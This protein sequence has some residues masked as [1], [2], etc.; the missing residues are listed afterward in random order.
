MPTRPYWRNLDQSPRVNP[1]VT[2]VSFHPCRCCKRLLLHSSR[3]EDVHTMILP[4]P[5]SRVDRTS[6]GVN[7]RS[8]FKTPLWHFGAQISQ[9]N[10]V[11]TLETGLWTACLVSRAKIDRLTWIV[12]RMVFCPQNRHRCGIIS[13]MPFFHPQGNAA[14][15]AAALLDPLSSLHS[16]T[17]PRFWELSSLLTPHDHRKALSDARPLK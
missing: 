16:D 2:A 10:P 13:Q 5:A 1:K 12:R 7:I 4:C 15:P 3:R 11:Y 6:Q 8:T 17:Q 9:R 14:D